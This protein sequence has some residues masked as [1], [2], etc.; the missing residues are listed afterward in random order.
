MGIFF[1]LTLIVA[2]TPLR[3][4]FIFTAKLIGAS[5]SANVWTFTGL[6]FASFRGLALGIIITFGQCVSSLSPIAIGYIGDHHSIATALW[7]VTVPCAFAAGVALIPTYVLKQSR[8]RQS[9]DNE[10]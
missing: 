10:N 5:G 1:M 4:L 6:V 9:A 7:T 8:S 3:A 2:P